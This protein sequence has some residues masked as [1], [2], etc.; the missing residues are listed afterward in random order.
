MAGHME[1]AFEIMQRFIDVGILRTEDYEVT[2]D[3]RSDM[4]YKKKSC[5]MILETQDA[6][7]YRIQYGGE[8]APEIGMMP[9][10]SGNGPDSDYLLAV[11]NYFMAANN[12]LEQ[13]GNEEKLARVMEIFAFLSTVEGQQAVILADSTMISSIRGMKWA[14]SE[15][16][17]GVKKTL[18]KGTW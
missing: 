18:K 3:Q 11:P 9:F 7:K 6:E 17:S 2:P 1:P 13:P 8:R 15:F 12:A 5:A 4:L 10:L 14:N 16:L